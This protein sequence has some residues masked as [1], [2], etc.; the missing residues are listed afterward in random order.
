MI[1]DEVFSDHQIL[2]QIA[3]PVGKDTTATVICTLVEHLLGRQQMTTARYVLRYLR[4]YI[5]RSKTR[6]VSS[7]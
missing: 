7:H 6:Y 4:L 5:V 1:C 2:F 3:L